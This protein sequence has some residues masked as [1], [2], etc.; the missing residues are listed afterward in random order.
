MQQ[1]QEEQVLV[2]SSGEWRLEMVVFGFSFTDSSPLLIDCWPP[3]F[4][5][6]ID[7]SPEFTELQ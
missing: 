6:E 4:T 2:A 3:L 1:Q 5:P 7:L